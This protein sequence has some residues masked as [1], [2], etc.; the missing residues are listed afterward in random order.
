ML[1][2]IFTDWLKL[3]VCFYNRAEAI[4]VVQYCISRYCNNYFLL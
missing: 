1:F 4:G 2:L 3:E